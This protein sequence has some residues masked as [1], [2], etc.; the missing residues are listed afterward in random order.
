MK[1]LRFNHSEKIAIT[2]SD[3][4][5]IEVWTASDR[6]GGRV[7]KSLAGQKAIL[8]SDGGDRWNS[9][10]EKAAF[11]QYHQIWLGEYPYGSWCY[12]IRQCLTTGE[13]VIHSIET[14]INPHGLTDSEVWLKECQSYV[15]TVAV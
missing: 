6:T 10:A 11:C 2:V 1:V 4:G 5:Q 14:E 8:S 7:F 13:V 15:P 9:R 12:A 3:D